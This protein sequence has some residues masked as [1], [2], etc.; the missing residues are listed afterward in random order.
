MHIEPWLSGKHVDRN[1]EIDL[2]RAIQEGHA[3]ELKERARELGKIDSNVLAG[4]IKF[5]DSA[6]SI[7]AT[8]E[9]VTR[10][11]VIAQRVIDHIEYLQGVLND[12][13]LNLTGDDLFKKVIRDQQILP[14]I[15]DSGITNIVLDNFHNACERIVRLQEEIDTLQHRENL[16]QEDETKLHDLE[17][18]KKDVV[19][20]LNEFLSGEAYE[21][22]LKMSLAY[23]NPAI[24]DNLTNISL[25]QFAKAKYGKEFS[26][27][28]ETGVGTT[29]A[30]I[31]ADYEECKRTTDKK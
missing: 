10:G 31:K 1:T 30:S 20:Q 4:E 25:Y 27:Y 8:D 22:Y 17:Q 13:Q 16:T 18:Q 23:L 5:G 15:K 19:E 14:L 7:S 21:P 12:Y 2:I 29:Q 24:R 26:S 28:P 9:Q 3:D 6:V 11:D